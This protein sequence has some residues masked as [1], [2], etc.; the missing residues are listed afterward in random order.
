[1]KSSNELED[2]RKQQAPI[3]HCE[4]SLGHSLIWGFMLICWDP[5]F[6][7]NG[8]RK[9]KGPSLGQLFLFDLA[10]R[11]SEDSNMQCMQRWLILTTSFVCW[12][13]FSAICNFKKYNKC[14]G[15][16]RKC[17]CPCRNSSAKFE[18]GLLKTVD[19]SELFKYYCFRQ[20]LGVT[21]GREQTKSRWTH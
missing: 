16:G 5:E 1:M 17:L 12:W 13:Q 18:E 7:W 9:R 2:A 19:T 11:G 6:D 21:Q 20:H 8:S 10:L 15:E 4:F 14:H 3:S